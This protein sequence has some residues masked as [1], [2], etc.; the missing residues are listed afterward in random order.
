M[1]LLLE[2]FVEKYMPSTDKKE[3]NDEDEYLEI[4]VP[5]DMFSEQALDNLK[6]MVLIV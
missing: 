2:R 5:R 3:A 1:D 4:S 6:I